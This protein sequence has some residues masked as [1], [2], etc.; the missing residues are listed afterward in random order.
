[1]SVCRCVGVL[2]CQCVSVLVCASFEMSEMCW[3]SAE[4]LTEMC[5]LVSRSGEKVFCCPLQVHMVRC[6]TVLMI[7]RQGCYLMHDGGAR[8]FINAV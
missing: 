2:L 4:A 8:V 1:M 6:F 3:S 7:V 5:Y